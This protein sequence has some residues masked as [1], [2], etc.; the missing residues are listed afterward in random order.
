MQRAGELDLGGTREGGTGVEL[1]LG[2]K[3]KLMRSM[4]S[5]DFCRIRLTFVG[6][7]DDGLL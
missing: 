1:W 4:L 5:Y 7:M 3:L 6:P 2:L